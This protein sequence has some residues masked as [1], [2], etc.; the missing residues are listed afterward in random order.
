[1]VFE[2]AIEFLE[3]DYF[4]GQHNMPYPIDH[5]TTHDMTNK[6]WKSNDWWNKVFGLKSV[7]KYNVHSSLFQLIGA[8]ILTFKWANNKNEVMCVLAQDKKG[9]MKH[10]S[11]NSWKGFYFRRRGHSARI[12][13]HS[14]LIELL[15]K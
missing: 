1:M 5:K 4:S 7:K 12:M 13:T 2:G 11:M 10:K 15:S 3:S 9:Q 6:L 14:N 8:G